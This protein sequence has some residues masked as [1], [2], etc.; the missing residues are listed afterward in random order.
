M[1]EMGTGNG[2]IRP[3]ECKN[4]TSLDH[5]RSYCVQDD[6]AKDDCRSI[7]T[8]SRRQPEICGTVSL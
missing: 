8:V 5:V 6:G 2:G 7:P 3:R 4:P 1:M